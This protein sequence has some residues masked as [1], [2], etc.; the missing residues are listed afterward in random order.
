M[1]WSLHSGDQVAL[2][3]VFQHEDAIA[4]SAR[5]DS[6]HYVSRRPRQLRRALAD[7]D[8]RSLPQVRCKHQSLCRCETAIHNALQDIGRRM[9]RRPTGYDQ[10]RRSKRTKKLLAFFTHRAVLVHNMYIDSPDY[11]SNRG[12]NP[13][14]SRKPGIWSAWKGASGEVSEPA[15]AQPEPEA[16]HV[17]IWPV[18]WRKRIER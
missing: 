1:K 14:P 7:H 3:L 16:A 10:H 4:L 8:L 9:T 6:N 13:V 15:V 17:F 12:F 18:G 5:T 2:I 11:R